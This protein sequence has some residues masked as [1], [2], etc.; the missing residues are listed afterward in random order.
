MGPYCQDFRVWIP[1]A[2]NIHR[3]TGDLNVEFAAEVAFAA[4]AK[5]LH[6]EDF[7]G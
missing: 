2:G 1:P 4:A 3:V 7:T 5:V 6:R